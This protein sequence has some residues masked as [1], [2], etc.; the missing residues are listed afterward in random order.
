MSV[1]VLFED[2]RNG[3]PAPAGRATTLSARIV[4]EVVD[5]L[6]ERRLAPGD[7]LGSEKEI[8]ARAGAS[9]IVARD[10]LRT[11]EALGVVEI[12]MGAGGG[13]R[14]AAGN[15]RR[16]AEALAI[17]L[18]LAGVGVGE[19]MD[20]QR[21]VE[22]QAAELAAEHASEADLARLQ[23]LLDEAEVLLG[24]LD[25]FTRASQDFH[26]A[27]AEASRNRVLVFDLVSLQHV[28]WPRRNRS[29]TREVAEHVLAT[30][31]ELLRHIAARDGAGARR[32]MDEHVR[33]IRARRMAE[34]GD[35]GNCC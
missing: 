12:R 11:L 13:A 21:A 20:A 9:R 8:A 10:A 35:A 15:P 1:Q 4:A 14:I 26:L 30:H 29:L 22:C 3:R 2:R 17:Q 34:A 19:I 5:A 27:I 33:V 31:R 25:G 6:L 23:A 28:S 7:A 24:D 32:L 16:F 18:A